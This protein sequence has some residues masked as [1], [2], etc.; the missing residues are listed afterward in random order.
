[1]TR[2]L[3]QKD[4]A[5]GAARDPNVL[6]IEDG[7][8]FRLLSDEIATWKQHVIE[9]PKDDEKVVFVTCPGPRTCPLDR[10]PVAVNP[11][12]SIKFEDGRPVNNFPIST[13]RAVNVWDYKSN[14]VKILIGG[15][16]VFD[17]F[18]E[19]A[20]NSVNVVGCDY[21]IGKTGAR[22]QTKYK[23]TRLDSSPG[24][25]VTADDLHDLSKY[26]APA[27]LEEIFKKLEDFGID[28]DSI[29]IPRF[30]L[31]DAL[32]YVMPYTKFKNMTIEA[33]V[34]QDEDYAKWL[35]G[36]K[37]E[38]GQ[39]GDPVFQALQTVLEDLGQAPPLDLDAV[40]SAAQAAST[41]TPQEKPVAD[42]VTLID[43]DGVPGEYPA[44]AKDALLAAG[45]VEPAPEPDP[46]P[47]AGTV[48]LIGPDGAKGEYPESAKGALLAA[49]YQLAGPLP[50]TD[51]PA[52]D[53][54]VLVG[55]DGAEID[56]SALPDAAVQAMLGQGYSYK[57]SVAS[58]PAPEPLVTADGNFV[59]EKDGQR[60]EIPEA[61]VPALEAQ[62]Y[63]KVM[64]GDAPPVAAL[65]APAPDEK[66]P[67]SLKAMPEGHVIEMPW[68]DAKRLFLSNDGEFAGDRAA[69]L[70]TIAARD[71]DKEDDR[72]VA[73]QVR[74]AAAAEQADSTAVPP[75]PADPERPFV[76]DRC[77]DKRYKTQ[78]AL[79]QH[80]NK[81]HGGVDQN[82]TG[83]GP[84]PAAAPPAATG[85][86]AVLDRVKTKIAASPLAKNYT[87][88]LEIFQ[89]AT[90]G[91][92]NLGDMT[93]E[94][95]TKVEA[96]LA[97]AEATGA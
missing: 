76:C 17:A 10:K 29:P 54:S 33:M 14:S 77:P 65:V 22:R 56:A 49:G 63:A 3:G 23:M 35:H 96:A 57:T 39:L 59:L 97:I 78:G 45:Y 8:R 74:N 95:L 31:D 2:R 62:G 5:N 16:Q 21:V 32:S 34:A 58:V 69:D 82:A 37:L 30:S 6:V 44:S 15:P 91:E 73:E 64:T 75:A 86:G 79:T 11:D 38:Q 83:A 93:D 1:M 25:T 90:G 42:L 71:A 12:G 40:P 4:P 27:A 18:D 89:E 43:K 68:A 55:P 13:R 46:E 26:E 52:V 72:A 70:R 88:L 36:T 92:R 61:A 9:D 20:R 81:E 60:V 53:T 84:A 94:Q 80:M 41:S 85:D 48:T 28:Y 50:A 47:A 7:T 66:V 67:F 19:D 87:K 51:A 24:P